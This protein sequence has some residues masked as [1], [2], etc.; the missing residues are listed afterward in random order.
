MTSQPMLSL[1]TSLPKDPARHHSVY[2]PDGVAALWEDFWSSRDNGVRNALV[3]AYQ[4]LVKLIVA[5]LPANIRTYWEK[6]DLQSFGL[7]GLMEAID[8][9]A[10]DSPRNRFAAYATKRVRGSVY[11][12]LRRLDWLPRAVR[13]NVVNYHDATESLTNR[14]GRTPESEEVLVE[15]GAVGTTRA[16]VLTSLQ[17]SQ[18]LHL[19]HV[20]GSASPSEPLRLIDVLVDHDGPAPDLQILVD[21]QSEQVRLAV[22]RLPERQ[23]TVIACHFLGGLTQEQIGLM[24]G[25]SNSRICQIEATALQTLRRVLGASKE[26]AI[27]Q[28]G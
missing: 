25:V 23:Q 1:I 13:R 7:L 24:L 11:D 17:S 27:Y 6:D 14:L 15:M 19:E 26:T 16:K 18:L 2:E 20:V 5:R 10:P 22:S 12:E 3:L 9:W 4:P 28:A 21:E 8:R